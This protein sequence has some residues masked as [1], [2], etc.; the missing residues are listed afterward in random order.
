M[1]KYSVVVKTQLNK[2]LREIDGKKVQG[3]FP[4]NSKTSVGFARAWLRRQSGFRGLFINSLCLRLRYG[5]VK[6]CLSLR[7]NEDRSQGQDQGK[8]SIFH[9]CK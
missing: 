6:I 5:R 7:Q 9:T 3:Y 4:T 8:E 1:E 2:T